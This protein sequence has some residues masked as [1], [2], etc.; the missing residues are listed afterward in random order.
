VTQKFRA[1][2][3]IDRDGCLIEEKH[4][5]HKPEDVSLYEQSITALKLLEDQ[6][7][8]R[9]ICTNQSGVAR[10]MF[11]EQDVEKV[12]DHLTAIIEKKGCSIQGIYSCFDHKDAVEEKYKQYLELRKPNPG[13]AEKAISDLGLEGIPVFAIG[14]KKIDVEFGENAGG[15]GVQVKTGHGQAELEESGNNPEHL[16]AD[17]ILDGVEMALNEIIKREFPED[18]TLKRK[19]KT[20]KQLANICSDLKAEGKRVGFANGC[21]DL[22][23][24]GHISFLENSRAAGDFLILGLNS[25]TSIKRLKGKERPILEEPARIQL[26]SA[27]KAVDF[28]TIFYEDSADETLKL[29]HPTYHAKGTDYRSDNVPEL[30]T[31]RKLGIETVIAGA[32]KENSTR[33]ILDVIIERSKSGLL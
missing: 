23:H 32:P 7:I 17:D 30:I 15:F 29:I 14:D 25:N 24:G 4:Y 1:L 13:M 22:I 16:V 19:L 28:I 33:D 18:E 10:G 20:R 2:A 12:H 6:N 21:F 5:L 8:A 9:V 26:L 27:L 11:S 3:L 31:T